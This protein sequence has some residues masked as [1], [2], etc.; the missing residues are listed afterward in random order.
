MKAFKIS[1]LLIVLLLVSALFVAGC[2][3]PAADVPAD[4]PAAE[5]GGEEAVAEE[6][7]TIII[8][9]KGWSESMTLG[10][11]A[12]LLIE[13]NTIH[14]VD[15]SK[16]NMG[17]TEILHPALVAGE[18]DLYPEYTGTAW[19]IILEQEA[20]PDPVEIFEKSRDAYMEQFGIT[21]LD[22]IGFNDTF[23]IA[24]TRERAEELGVTKLSELAAIPDLTFIGDS[25]TFTRPDLLGLKEAYGLDMETIDRVIVDTSFFYEALEQGAGDLVTL[26]ST[27][28]KLSEYDFIILEDDKGYFPPYD[29]IYVLRP[30]L[31]DE[32]PSIA[33]ALAPLLGSID[34]ETMIELNHKVD[35]EMLDPEDVAREYLESV[36]LI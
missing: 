23:A 4:D 3:Q 36:G 31:L 15:T 8:A 24:M 25:T 11:M 32:Y 29:A 14:S 5:E 28:G 17:P 10:Y 21:M 20:I 6:P 18:I 7:G 1:A 9:A 16:I 22:P 33:D 35:V 27:D 26:F 30:G 34:E 19:M 12:A 2:S 13:A